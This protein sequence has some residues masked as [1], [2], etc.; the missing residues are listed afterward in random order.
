MICRKVIE[1]DL[2]MLFTESVDTS[3]FVPAC[4]I[5]PK[6]NALVLT[7]ANDVR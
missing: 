5:Y 3:A 6:V 2:L 1:M 4:S 7:F